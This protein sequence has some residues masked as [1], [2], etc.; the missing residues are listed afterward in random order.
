MGQKSNTGYG[1]RARSIATF[2]LIMTVGTA[3]RAGEKVL[4]AF[5]GGNDGLA[6]YGALI[7][8][9]SGNLYGTT[10]EGG[11]TGC[12]FG[13]GCGT[14]FRLAPDRSE[15]VLYAFQGGNDGAF[16]DGSLVVDN[17]GNYYG[18][19]SNGGS[20]NAGTVFRLSPG[21][22]ETPLYAFTGGSDGSQPA[23]SLVIDSEGNLYGTAGGGYNGGDCAP[24]LGCG[25]VFAVAPSGDENVLYT[26]QGIS[27]GLG[28]DNVIRDNSGN[29]YGVTV[30]GGIVCNQ[31]ATGG[32]GTV[33]ELAPDGTKTILYEFQ[34]GSDGISPSGSLL[35]DKSGDL[36]GTTVEGGTGCANSCGTIFR[37]APDGTETVLYAFKGGDDGVAPEAGLVMDKSG[38]LYGTTSLGGG[39][40]YKNTNGCGTT[41]KLAPNGKETVL[42]R[43]GSHGA[44][45]NPDSSLLFG[46][47]GELNGTTSSGGAHKD[48]VVFEVKK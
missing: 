4:H 10:S 15:T 45:A 26:F 43:F 48:G 11:G 47:H 35:M 40:C 20:S 27:D 19:T 18:E 12:A 7:S 21:G 25:V 34:G 23:N 14:I 16:P 22:T 41:F 9:A 30:A 17:V 6:P 32:C 31:Y 37:L 8:D 42:L 1:R 28:P 5:Q 29:L 46:K 36:F 38:N 44:G 24:Y 13:K 2:V 39:Q 3:A 33:Y